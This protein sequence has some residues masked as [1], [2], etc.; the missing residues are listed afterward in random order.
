MTPTARLR[1]TSFEYATGHGIL[2]IQERQTGEWIADI[3]ELMLTVN[4]WQIWHQP[5]DE[6]AVFN[7]AVEALKAA[8]A[9][10]EKREQPEIPDEITELYHPTNHATV[11][12]LSDFSCIIE[13]IG[14]ELRFQKRT[15]G[16]WEFDEIV[17]ECRLHIE[18]MNDNSY[19]LGI[20][21]A[22]GIVHVNIGTKRA[23]VQMT[24]WAEHA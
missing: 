23:P 6:R 24:G 19:W 4:G 3:T 7:T 16:A 21:T 1:A 2:Q 17:G 5:H 20:T 10:L 11:T 18:Q 22:S 12:K 9:A 8:V 13:D 15:D 14:M